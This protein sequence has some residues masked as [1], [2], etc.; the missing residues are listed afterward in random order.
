MCNQSVGLIQRVIEQEKIATI[1]ISLSRD[2]T[3]KVRPPRALYPGFPMGHPL[4][5]PHRAGQQ[6][7]VLRYLLYCLKTIS[8]PG[9]LVDVDLTR[10]ENCHPVG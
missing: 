7:Y 9:T 10:S 8:K 2:V 1:S 5:Y 3:R 6:R 4:G